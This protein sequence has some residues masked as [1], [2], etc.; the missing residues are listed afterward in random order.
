MWN[1]R[2]SVA[3]TKAPKV[4]TTSSLPKKLVVKNTR[5]TDLKP[6]NLVSVST[7]EHKCEV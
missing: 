4:L 3:Y 5:L 1:S 2:G 6:A 7:S